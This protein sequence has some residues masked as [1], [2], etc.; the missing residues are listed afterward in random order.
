MEARIFLGGWHRKSDEGL[1][2][3]L[4]RGLL[5]QEVLALP[6]VPAKCREKEGREGEF[7]GRWNRRR[8]CSRHVAGENTVPVGTR[9]FIAP[10]SVP[11]AGI[12][13][14]GGDKS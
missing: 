9:R 2:V 1:K 14:T 3:R 4:A 13:A 12:H 11:K 7:S 8:T 10:N 6:Y 5:F